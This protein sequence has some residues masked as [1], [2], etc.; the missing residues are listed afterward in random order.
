[1]QQDDVPAASVCLLYQGKAVWVEG[2]G[3]TDLKSKRRVGAGTIFSIQST[4]KNFTA[5]AIMLAVQRGLL[6]LD[7]P[8]TA[9]VPDFTVHRRFE[10]APQEK[11]TLRLLLSHRAGFT[12]EAPVARTCAEFG[13]QRTIR[14]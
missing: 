3:V 13:F 11:M 6:D 4:S 9:Y 5:T 10:S 7:K 2:F 12:H 14:D 1:M 8:I